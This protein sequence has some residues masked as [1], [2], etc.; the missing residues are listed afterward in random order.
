MTLNGVPTILD[1]PSQSW[2]A[3]HLLL[4]LNRAAKSMSKQSA[5]HEWLGDSQKVGMPHGRVGMFP[6]K[7][8]GMQVLAG[9]AP[10]S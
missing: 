6:R 4:N 10:S 8:G 3:L 1:S 2:V 9:L 5:A 7:E